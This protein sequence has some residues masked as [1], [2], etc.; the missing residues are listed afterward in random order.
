MQNS[1]TRTA[2]LD[3]N[4]KSVG[5]DGSALATTFLKLPRFPDT[6]LIGSI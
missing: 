4:G 3:D 5:L 2:W 1:L 6:D